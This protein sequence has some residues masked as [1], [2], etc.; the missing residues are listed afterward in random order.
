[1]IQRRF[2]F[3]RTRRL[4]QTRSWVVFFSI[5]GGFGPRRGRFRAR[6]VK[7]RGR[8]RGAVPTGRTWSWAA[9][10]RLHAVAALRDAWSRRAGLA[11]TATGPGR[12]RGP[13]R[14]PP[15]RR[16]DVGAAARRRGPRAARCGSRGRA[17]ASRAP[18]SAC[19]C[20]KEPPHSLPPHTR[21][22]REAGAASTPSTRPHES[23]PISAREIPECV[24]AAQGSGSAPR[25]LSRE[26]LS[27][28]ATC[29]PRARPG[30]NAEPCKMNLAIR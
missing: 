29:L 22:L 15:R 16:R 20:P 10:R 17:G 6:P 18:P 3:T 21:L 11:A 14:R 2:H 12:R 4:R 24:R 1:M 27:R 9:R 25:R 8:R 26:V 19:V 13:V 23:L 28:W 7:F 5:L 30:G